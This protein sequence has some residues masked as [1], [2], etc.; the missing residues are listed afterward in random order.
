MLKLGEKIISDIYLGDKKIAKVFLGDKLVY[1]A[2]KPIFL[3]YVHFD[4]NSYVDTGIALQTCTVETA[5]KYEY[6]N[7]R[8]MLSGW[9]GYNN[10]YWGMQTN[11]QFE[12]GG[13]ELNSNTNLTDYTEIKIVYDINAL[14]A[15]PMVDGYTKTYTI[16]SSS[17]EKYTIGCSVP[18]S[19]NKVIGNVYYHRF[20]NAE[21]E[22]IQDLR[23]CLDTKGVVCFYDLIT[24]TYFYNKGTGTLTAGNKIKFVDYVTTDGNSYIDVDFCPSDNTYIEYTF[25]VLKKPANFQGLF[26]S[27]QDTAYYTYNVFVTGSQAFRIDYGRYDETAYFFDLN[28]KYTIKAG[29]NAVYL[30]DELLKSYTVSYKGTSPYSMFLGNF[31]NKGTLYATGTAQNIYPCKIKENNVLVRDLRPCVSNGVVGFY[32]MVT[33]KIFTNAG[34]GE[35]KAS[36]RFVTSIL[37]DGASYI[38]T[39]IYGNQNTK[40]ETE[41]FIDATNSAGFAYGSRTGATA[42][43][44][45][46]SI[47]STN[48]N[49]YAGFGQTNNLLYHS[50]EVLSIIKNKITT[51]HDI[52]GVYIN[53][54]K[55]LD[56]ATASDFTTPTPIMVGATF[57][58]SETDSRRFKGKYYAF[59]LCE[60]NVLVQDLR[61]YVDADGIAC[62]KDVVTGDLFYNQGT[63]TLG[64]TE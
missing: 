38:D 47:D 58:G 37:F 3:D 51:S 48:G 39:G 28:K 63:G 32:D 62:F 59:K 53:G 45:T 6:N 10:L 2:N 40:I 16:S 26:G 46:L 18:T 9:V 5:V 11:G 7:T 36:P 52:N 50:A 27:R 13:G 41:I 57:N 17:P 23:P 1:Q 30:N 43:T 20:I 25:E 8:R 56:M 31:N 61:P 42:N 44:F 55:C 24:R 29:D 64:Y 22:L 49:I 4:G 33:G 21:G 35:L 15:T 12:L 54:N 19:G 60:N 14:T 34:T